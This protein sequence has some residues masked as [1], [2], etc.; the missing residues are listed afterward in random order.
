MFSGFKSLN[1]LLFLCISLL[2]VSCGSSTGS[3]T[4]MED[5]ITDPMQVQMFKKNINYEGMDR[6]P[7]IIVHGFLGSSLIDPKTKDSLWGSFRAIDAISI[8][9]KKMY[10][11]AY[12]MEYGVKLDSLKD[13]VE[14]GCLLESVK[15]SICGI[16][17]QVGAYKDLVDIMTRGGYVSDSRPMPEGKHFYSLFEFA[18]DWR[19]PIPKSSVQL[20]EFIKQKKEYL[21]KEYEKLYGVK[22]FDVQFDIIGHSMGGLVSKYYL[23]YGNQL[24]PEDGSLPEVTWKGSEDIDRLIVMG[25]PNAGY[26]DTFLELQRGGKLQPYP[27]PALGTLPTYYQMLP[28]L[29]SHSIVYSD[30]PDGMI[31]YFDVDVWIKNKWGLASPDIDNTLKILLP[32]IKTSE[33]R[34]KIALD[35]LDK[36]LKSAKQFISA[37]SVQEVPPADVRLDLF[38]GYGIMTTKRAFI[39]RKT[40]TIENVEYDSGDGKILA[41][42]ALYDRNTEQHWGYFLNSPVQW[43]NVTILRAAHMGITRDP[44]FADNI[45]FMLMSEETLQQKI[46]LG[47]IKIDQPNH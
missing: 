3:Y 25:T 37:M 29:Y 14:V 28:A 41:T 27:P 24:L 9:D 33:D 16:P 6:N 43:D 7:L 21:Q 19:Q 2:F 36:C 26:L 39:N 11:I 8:S 13:N 1:V 31:D 47:K 15:I 5:R 34:R 22:N 4:S 38:L 30:D 45:L 42:S 18:Y 20:G 32:G 23:M 10:E 35:H 17:F 44:T 46:V 40:G 12:P